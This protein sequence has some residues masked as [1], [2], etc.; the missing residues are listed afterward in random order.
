M[1]IVRFKPRT[2]KYALRSGSFLLAKICESNFNASQNLC[3]MEANSTSQ[4]TFAFYKVGNVALRP[5]LLEI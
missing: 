3:L 1:N 2:Y 4:Q 5:S